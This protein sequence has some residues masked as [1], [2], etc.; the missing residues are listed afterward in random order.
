MNHSAPNSGWTV[1]TAASASASAGPSSSSSANLAATSSAS[2]GATASASSR[3]GRRL[4]RE[5]TEILMGFYNTVST[6]PKKDQRIA[7]AEQIARIPG[8]EDYNEQKVS[9]YFAYRRNADKT[10]T[11]RAGPTTSAQILYPSLIRHPDILPAV[12][13]CLKDIPEPSPAIAELMATRIGHGAK[14]GD[15]L[16]YAQLRRE[17][18]GTPPPPP[19]TAPS[20]STGP[21]ACHPYPSPG[22]LRYVQ[23]P[24]APNALQN[25]QYPPAPGVQI[26]KSGLRLPP[27][28][29]SA[30]PPPRSQLPTPASSTSPEPRSPV[31]ANRWGKVEVEADD[32]E[33]VK[34]E[35][36]SDDE[37][38]LGTEEGSEQ[39]PEVSMQH[40]LHDLAGDLQQSLSSLQSCSAPPKT[41]AEL[42]GWLKQQDTTSSA[43]LRGIS[44]GAYAPL[45]LNAAPTSPTMAQ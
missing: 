37:E 41:F 17:Q 19:P 1:L 14:F 10:R 15:I 43:V 25:H 39:P 30:L 5:A 42:A 31:V 23:Q 16:A 12:D 8:Y 26:F 40:R 20:V 7:L 35:L 22:S 38:V 33:D 11:A 29:R 28:E 18:S 6:R 34:D 2:N 21:S 32:D 44:Q 36:C 27:F 45:G 3:R 24:P 13:A 9:N 4:P